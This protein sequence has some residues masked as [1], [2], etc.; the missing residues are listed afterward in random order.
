MQ[1]L[2]LRGMI[3]FRVYGFS[4]V[5]TEILYKERATSTS[6]IDWI[7]SSACQS[8]KPSRAIPHSTPFGISLTSFLTCLSVET[9]PEE[10]NVC[11]HRTSLEREEKARGEPVKSVSPFRITRALRAFWTTP[12]KTLLPAILIGC[13][14]PLTEISKTI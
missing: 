9:V 14:R 3:Q 11:Q 1:L 12:L 4:D 7:K 2:E 5:S 6:S 8:S 13:L 10:G